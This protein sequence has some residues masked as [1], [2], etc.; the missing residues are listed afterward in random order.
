[1]RVM[2]MMI[3]SS[4]QSLLWLMVLLIMLLYVVAI[5]VTQGATEYLRQGGGEFSEAMDSQFGS[6]WST[7]YTLFKCMCGG[8]SWGESADPLLNYNLMYF[9]VFLVYIF[10]ALFSFVNIVTGVFVDSAIQTA[11][12][13]RSIVVEKQ[14]KHKEAMIKN[15][16]VVLEEI[17]TDSS[18]TLTVQELMQAFNNQHLANFFAHL[19]IEMRDM[20]Q[21]MYLLDEDGNGSIDIVEFV[22][23]LQACCGAAR[24]L[25]ISILMKQMGRMSVEIND[26]IKRLPVP[27]QTVKKDTREAKRKE[28]I[29]P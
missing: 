19:N 15:L 6:L 11:D 27:P 4:L 9:L 26:V 20:R 14:R 12:R 7:M 16:L 2:A 13:D 8:V 29:G 22:D 3:V 25:D 5:V 21:L 1:L 17:D 23:G 18:G 28:L 10:F 24:S